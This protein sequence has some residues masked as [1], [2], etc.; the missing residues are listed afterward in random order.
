MALFT[1]ADVE[2]VA[3]IEIRGDA[4]FRIRSLESLSLLW[5]ARASELIHPYIAVIQQARR[6]GMKAWLERP[7][8]TVGRATWQ[9][10]A[11]WY[12]GAIAHDAY[13]SKLYQEAKKAL[14][15]AAPDADAWTGV[16]A[17]R[18]C[19]EF[20]RQVLQQL[21]ADSTMLAY[22]EDLAKDPVYQGRARGWGSR[23]D[24]RKRW[25]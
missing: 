3:G 11:L 19:L 16:T 4:E 23:L 21:D 10:S 25:W 8:L 13:H 17:E 22:I 2:I 1:R 12:A 18:Q 5:R 6:S 9:H 7:T 20:Q 24:Y 14:G 15:G